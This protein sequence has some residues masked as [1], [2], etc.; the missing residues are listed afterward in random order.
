MSTV[1]S[2][3][4]AVVGVVQPARVGITPDLRIDAMQRKLPAHLSPVMWC[5]GPP[6]T[7]AGTARWRMAG[8]GCTVAD[9]WAVR[10]VTSTL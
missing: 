8:A 6:D 10:G 4:E 9:W 2:G 5:A 7:R 3:G 1:R